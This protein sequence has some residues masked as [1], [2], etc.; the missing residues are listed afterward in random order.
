MNAATTRSVIA[1]AGLAAIG[2]IAWPHQATPQARQGVPTVHRDVALVD[3]TDSTLLTDEVTLDDALYTDLTSGESSLY[4]A[5]ATATTSTDA[6]DLLGAS[7]SAPYD[8]IFDS[9]YNYD[10]S[11]FAL[12]VYATED[13]V[14][15][16]LGISATTSETDILAD[17]QADPILLTGTD[18][19]PT[20]GASGFDSD[21]ITLA[22]DDYATGSTDFTTYL[23]GLSTAVS[24][25]GSTDT[26]D[27]LTAALTELSTLY[28]ADAS[29]LS[30]D[31]TAIFTD[32][33]SLF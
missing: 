20:A 16:L 3:V 29:A 8:G 21:L 22:D 2:F 32:L 6:T 12:D 31:L 28:A 30:T 27:G 18:A 10:A 17:L 24:T 11:G 23:D 5:V 13:E 15:Q 26:S 19:L 14:N 4:D 1:A 7:T 9:A 33:G 25:V